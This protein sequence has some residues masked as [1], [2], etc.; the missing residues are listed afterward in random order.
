MGYVSYVGFTTYRCATVKIHLYFKRLMFMQI[1]CIK[2]KN[3]N[4]KTGRH[5]HRPPASTLS[6]ANALLSS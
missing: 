5:N 2:I 1:F 6:L 4:K 3:I